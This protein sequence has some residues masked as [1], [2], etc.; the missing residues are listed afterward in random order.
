MNDDNSLKQDVK[1]QISQAEKINTG[2]QALS[3]ISDIKT[4][5]AQSRGRVGFPGGV[6]KVLQNVKGT[7]LDVADT[8]VEAGVIDEESYE[9]AKNKIDQSV[10][11]DLA[12][13]YQQA[14]PDRN[15]TDFY[16]D[17]ESDENKIYQEFFIKPR[18]NY[19]QTL[20]ANTIKLN[21]IYYAI[22]RARKPTGRLNVD[23]V[24][25]AKES[26]KLYDI[27][28][29]SDT[30]ITSLSAIE[31]ELQ[32]FVNAQKQIYEKAGYEK[33]FLYNY[34]PTRFST[35]QELQNQD[36]NKSLDGATEFVDP[37]ADLELPE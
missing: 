1:G 21:S 23:D 36:P 28:T 37:Y 29:S 9:A 3:F 17:K 4:S 18:E 12:N 31:N 30:V 13:T 24:N 35:E 22:A 5:I 27:N 10:F 2:N 25:N 16:A 8:F 20:A 19:D 6:K 14:Y 7:I 33:G 34:N 26:L 15:A 32:G 11:N